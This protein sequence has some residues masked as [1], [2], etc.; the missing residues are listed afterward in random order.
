MP[1]PGSRVVVK[2]APSNICYVYYILRSYRNENGRPKSDE[3]LIGKKSNTEGFLIPNNNYYLLFNN[4]IK[5][6]GDLIADSN[7]I[8]KIIAAKIANKNIKRVN[9][10][11]LLTDF[12]SSDNVK[13][14]IDIN[15]LQLDSESFFAKQEQYGHIFALMKV[16]ES[17]GLTPILQKVFPDR[18][19]QIMTIA[20]FM[21]TE[22]NIM[23][24]ILHWFE[25]SRVTLV[26][27]MTDQI[28]S[29]VF[30]NIEYQEKMLFFKEWIAARLESEYLI[31]D[32][33]SISTHSKNI[34]EVER[35]HNSDEES[36]AQINYGMFYGH[37][38]RLPVY[39]DEYQGSI[40][41]VSTLPFI[42]NQTTNLGIKNVS[43]VLDRG[44]LSEHNLHYLHDHNYKF[45]IPLSKNLNINKS[46]IDNYAQTVKQPANWLEKHKLYGICVDSTIFNI[47]FKSFIY[48]DHVKAHEEESIIY[49]KISSKEA[50]LLKL[51]SKN[52]IKK[53]FNDFFDIDII[54]NDTNFIFNRNND[55][56]NEIINRCGFFIYISNFDLIDPSKLLSTYKKRYEIEQNFKIF[57][58]DLI[59]KRLRTQYDKTT[60][61][62]LFIGFLAL[63]LRTAFFNK[64]I[65]CS[66]TKNMTISDI[67]T[68]LKLIKVSNINNNNNISI[69][70]PLSKFQKDI[71][72]S[73]GV[74]ISEL[75]PT[76][77]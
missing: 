24:K 20:I 61:G 47:P 3:V 66:S 36:L 25:Q 29:D 50:E 44:F 74:L 38:S 57:K 32:V 17:I 28:C 77:N 49:D 1:I 21:A 65:K 53:S 67:L 60:E 19:N 22:G 23:S 14:I 18:W 58:Q 30:K 56:I 27:K 76:N 45:T 42:L 10:S 8:D 69:K 13:S 35:G 41:D 16:S 40:P 33:T 51:K 64:V 63:I 12:S 7:Y 34:S 52:L 37:S 55:K 6:N 2:K 59:F 70:M 11:E 46:L 43:L 4:S 71:Y 5:N 9:V 31:Y 68:K 72:D 15:N 75:A 26:T 62:K 73:I 48:F 39:Y 54:N